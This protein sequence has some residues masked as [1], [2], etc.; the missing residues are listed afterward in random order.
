MVT[1]LHGLSNKQWLR[2]MERGGLYGYLERIEKTKTA[3]QERQQAFRREARSLGG[4]LLR[5]DKLAHFSFG[6]RSVY[7]DSVRDTHWPD[8]W[9][10]T[11]DGHSVTSEVSLAD[12]VK[13]I[14]MEVKKARG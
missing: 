10:V 7:A 9:E 2:E 12:A 11:V 8:Y 4:L 5:L 3:K 14:V 1:G 6:V 13:Q